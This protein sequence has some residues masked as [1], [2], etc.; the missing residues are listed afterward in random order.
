MRKLTSLFLA[1]ILLSSALV[2]CQKNEVDNTAK[3]ETKQEASQKT[4]TKKQDKKDDY[5]LTVLMETKSWGG[6]DEP[7]IAKAFKEYAEEKVGVTID[8][9]APPHNSYNERLNVLLVSGEKLDVIKFQGAP[10]YLPG[11]ITKGQILPLNEQMKDSQI[12]SD[13]YSNF[14]S[15]YDEFSV[16]GNVFGLPM[17]KPSEQFIWVRKDIFE[18]HDMKIPTTTDEFVTELS[19][20]KGENIIPFSFPKWI[21]NMQY[22]FNSFDAYLGFAKDDSGKWY[23]GFTTDEM[24]D[25]LLW[26]NTL[27]SEGL[28]DPEFMVNENKTMREKQWAGKAASYLYWDKLYTKN[29]IEGKKINPETQ[30]VAIPFLKGPNGEGKAFNC[31]INDAFAVGAKSERPDLA[32][33]F[34]E[35][36]LYTSEGQIATKLGVEGVSYE[37]KDGIFAYTEQGEAA[38]Y[39]DSPTNLFLKTLNTME[40]PFEFKMSDE[41]VAYTNE[42][43]RILDEAKTIPLN[44]RY[45]VPVGTSNTFDTKVNPEYETKSHEL[46]IKVIMG[47]IS[48]EECYERWEKFSK[49]VQIDKALEELNQQ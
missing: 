20:L 2:G 38:G 43:Q 28:L 5:E 6:T 16:D 40:F 35:W 26:L 32:V 7:K 49:A 21:V 27:Y 34:M 45:I 8:M 39:A 15:Y 46:I 22:F 44:K 30:N 9:I 29:Q 13:H 33:K 11:A 3:E 31:G 47:E 14:Q 25:A 17:Q 42:Q 23:D 10:R 41:E 48:I 37:V 4:E 36:L 19:K 12:I 1:T 18:K 24:K